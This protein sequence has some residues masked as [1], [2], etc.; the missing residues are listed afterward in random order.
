[1]DRFKPTLSVIFQRLL[2]SSR[3]RSAT[4]DF[5]VFLFVINV[6][7][8]TQGEGNWEK[9]KEQGI[10]PWLDDGNYAPDYPGSNTGKS[11]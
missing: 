5:D 11:R 9:L 1:M 2:R 3:A 4:G 6:K 7:S 10:L 8:Q